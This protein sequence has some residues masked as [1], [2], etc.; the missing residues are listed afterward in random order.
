MESL[1]EKIKT[2]Q[3]VIRK[4]HRMFS[5]K[6]TVVAWTGGKDSTALLYLIRMTFQNKVPFPVMFND[7]KMEFD[8]IY[9]FI[10]RLQKDWN[11]DLIIVPHDG[12]E[13]REFY[14]A[15][16]ERKKELSRLMKVNAIARFVKQHGIEAFMVGIRWDEHKARSKEKYFSKRQDHMRVHPILHFTE[17]DI[18][19]LI[20]T[21]N[22][23][24]VSLYDKGYRSLGERPFTNK[25][26]P[27]MGERSGREYDK[28]QLMQEL[29]NMGYW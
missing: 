14:R 22:V 3:K 17:R 24:Y 12:K 13:L 10:R 11:I 29:R 15:D 20:R 9:E 7:S 27:G 25:A 19:A 26:I 4:A 21:Y 5:P 2:A 18:W 16:S 8:E 6:K 28:E 1:E 23:P